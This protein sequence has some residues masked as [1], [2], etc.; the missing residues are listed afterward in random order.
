L[1][2]GTG[3]GYR[4]G[5]VQVFTSLRAAITIPTLASGLHARAEINQ[6]VNDMQARATF[7]GAR[8][9]KS[10]VAVL[11]ALLVAYLLGGAS[12]YVIKAIGLPNATA[13][14]KLQAAEVYPLSDASTRS[15]RG[16]PQTVERQTPNGTAAGETATRHGGL[17]LP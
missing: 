16:G 10:V 5:H 13:T 1:K 4:P 7:G 15:L 11:V 17:Q 14:Q 9:S 2:T 8:I 12:G 6:E 3:F